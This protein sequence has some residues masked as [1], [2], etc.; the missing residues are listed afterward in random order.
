MYSCLSWFIQNHIADSTCDIMIPDDMKSR[1][2]KPNPRTKDGCIGIKARL[3]CIRR[4]E[5]GKRE[6]N[7]QSG[8]EIRKRE[9]RLGKQS[10]NT[11]NTH[12]NKQTK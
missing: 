1:T 8:Q 3:T 2:I 9:K 6:N 7:R 11:I 4:G 5:R 10:R 12:A